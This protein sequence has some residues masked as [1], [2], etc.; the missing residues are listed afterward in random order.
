MA[1]VAGAAGI[2]SAFSF[3]LPPLEGSLVLGSSIGLIMAGPVSGLGAHSPNREKWRTPEERLNEAVAVRRRAA[4]IEREAALEGFDRVLVTVEKVGDPLFGGRVGREFE[5]SMARM[6]EHYPEWDPEGR[7][8]T[9][10]LLKKIGSNLNAGNA[11]AYLEVAYRT[12]EARGKEAAQISHDTLGG[13]VELIYRDPES[14]S[15]RHL[16]GTLL[17][18][19]RDDLRYI[20]GIV[21]DALHLWSDERFEGLLLDFRALIAMPEET[22]AE[23]E[24]LLKKEMA[25]AA[26]A[27]DASAMARAREILRVVIPGAPLRA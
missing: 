25:K 2:A 5:L 4:K 26:R 8:R 9:Y 13:R 10:F 19:N 14:G 1:L 20:E 7:L 15:A 24:T 3:L 11:G 21:T 22:K 17:L 6:T 23:V 18:M 27:R 16:A 12:L